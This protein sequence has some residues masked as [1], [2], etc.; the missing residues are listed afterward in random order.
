M[1][2]QTMSQLANNQD[3]F[4]R[5]IY[6]DEKTAQLTRKEQD[7]PS[8]ALKKQGAYLFGQS[9]PSAVRAVIGAAKENH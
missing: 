3:Y 2:I 5:P 8:E 4:G 7:T 9:S 6:I 1:P